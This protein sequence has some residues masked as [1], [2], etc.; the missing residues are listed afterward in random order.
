M[1]ALYYSQ[2][3]RLVCMIISREWGRSKII[4]IFHRNMMEKEVRKKVFKKPV[5]KASPKKMASKNFTSK[6]ITLSVNFS[7]NTED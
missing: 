4:E 5:Y 2:L 6:F 1:P 3:K 7:C